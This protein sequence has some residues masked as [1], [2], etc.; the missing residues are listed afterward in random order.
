MDG[1]TAVLDV[2]KIEQLTYCL[3]FENITNIFL[4]EK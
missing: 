3:H 2:Y 1:H 4:T